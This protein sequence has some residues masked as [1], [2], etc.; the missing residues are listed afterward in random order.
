MLFRSPGVKT[1]IEKYLPQLEGITPKVIVNVAGADVE[2]YCEVTRHFNDC[3]GVAAVELNVSCPNV[4][5]GGMAFGCDPVACAG[6]V[7]AVRKCTQLPLIVKLTPNVTDIRLPARAAV[8]SGADI[9]SLVNTLSGVA[10]DVLTRKPILGNVAGGLSGP[11]IKPIALAKLLDVHRM[12]LGAPL[13]GM[14]GIVGAEDALEFMIT[15]ARAFAVGTILLRDP[16][17]P[18]HILSDLVER[19]N[20][21]GVTDINDLVG[22]IALEQ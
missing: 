22:T 18:A 5:L 17:S 3:A 16:M 7:S 8:E 6:V 13:I 10:V 15:G 9:L 11:A 4:K 20:A 1:V 2:E 21:L 14:G 12:D 19:C